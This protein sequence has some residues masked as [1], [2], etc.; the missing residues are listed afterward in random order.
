MAAF[1][2][3]YLYINLLFDEVARQDR[4]KYV[5]QGNMSAKDSN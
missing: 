5:R 2:L 1:S 3:P 4:E